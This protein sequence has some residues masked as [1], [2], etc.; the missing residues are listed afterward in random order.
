MYCIASEIVHHFSLT[1]RWK[2]LSQLR[3]LIIAKKTTE[4]AAFP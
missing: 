1:F 2:S 3:E 4:T